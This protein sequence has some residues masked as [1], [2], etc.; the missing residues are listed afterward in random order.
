MGPHTVGYTGQEGYV[1]ISVDASEK[2][3]SLGV[4]L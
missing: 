4:F 3:P 2:F 1:I